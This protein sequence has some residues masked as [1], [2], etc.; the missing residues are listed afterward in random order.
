[1]REKCADLQYVI[2]GRHP[3]RCSLKAVNGTLLGS[4]AMVSVL[5]SPA[6]HNTDRGI[7]DYFR[8][9]LSLLSILIG[10][11]VVP[12]SQHEIALPL[13]NLLAERQHT[14]VTYKL[15]IESMSFLVSSVESSV[16]LHV[17]F[18]N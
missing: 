3:C 13:A 2:L 10:G 5:L 17:P 14:K 9:L 12:L 6:A 15:K 16:L 18:S 8:C 7:I 1:M 4:V 11:G